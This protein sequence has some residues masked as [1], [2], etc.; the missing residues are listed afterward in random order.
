MT[1]KFLGYGSPEALEAAITAGE[2]ENFTVNEHF[3]FSVACSS[4]SKDEVIARMA[5]RPC[6]TRHGWQFSEETF[7]KGEP[8]PCPC[9]KF[10]ETHKHYLFAC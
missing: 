8:N 10:P 4:L 9:G 6:G 2:G 1:E 3:L 7:P 5:R